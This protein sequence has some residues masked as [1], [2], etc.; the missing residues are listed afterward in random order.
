MVQNGP[1]LVVL[2]TSNGY[3]GM[4]NINGGTLQLGTCASGQD[5]SLP[6]T[7]G[8][9]NNWTLAY[10][11]YGSQTTAYSIGGVGGV[12]KAGPGTCQ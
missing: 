8:V 10:N 11:L 7:N 3:T 2:T 5:G 4:T 9:N 6:G 1:G 12:E